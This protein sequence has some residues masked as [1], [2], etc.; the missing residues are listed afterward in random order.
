MGTT[1]QLACAS[2]EFGSSDC[3]EASHHEAQMIKKARFYG[4]VSTLDDESV[5]SQLRWAREEAARIGYV[6]PEG[7]GYVYADDHIS[8]VRRDRFGLETLIAD[9]TSADPAHSGA[10]ADLI[11]IRDRARLWRGFDPRFPIHLEYLFDQHGTKII[12]GDSERTIDYSDGVSDADIGL[13]ISNVVDTVGAARE[14]TRMMRKFRQR[15]RELVK[16]GFFPAGA[17]PY[18][19]ER[20]LVRRETGEVVQV[21]PPDMT[22]R[23]PG[24]HFKLRV[25]RDPEDPEKFSPEA[26]VVAFIFD[27]IEAGRSLYGITVDLEHRGIVSPTGQPQW[28]VSMI[29]QIASNEL[30]MGTLIWGRRR[31]AKGSGRH[32]PQQPVPHTEALL[33]GTEPIRYDGFIA[34]PLVSTEQF[35]RVRQILGGYQTLWRRRRATKPRYLLTGKVTC[36]NCGAIL[37][38]YTANRG[39]SKERVYYR[40]RRGYK[41]RSAGCRDCGGSVRAEGLEAAVLEK[42]R[43]LLVSGELESLVREEL[44]SLRAGAQRGEK[45]SALNRARRQVSRLDR[46][47][48]SAVEAEI[49]AQSESRKS[50]L[51]AASERISLALDAAKLELAYLEAEEDE[52]ASAAR[53]PLQIAADAASLVDQLDR[54]TYADRRA[55][56]E[57]VVKS[58][59]F[60]REEHRAEV[61]IRVL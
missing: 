39:T 8:G 54:M 6:I 31:K 52:L 40:H 26:E 10:D 23:Q 1:V 60:F 41:N 27:S 35:E 21:V 56:V 18:G 3:A 32:N 4:R 61:L 57:R 22:V 28:S 46:R 53:Q 14:R 13:F 7:P 48:D 29:S 20:I 59:R 34:E 5:D 37:Y 25:A 50:K 11:L 42:I 2:L 44:E 45:A 24:C 43:E 19:L 16:D 33:T 49:G 47:L 17:V 36:S 9:V 15:R 51:R 58:I 55:V 12:F 30:Y 38:G